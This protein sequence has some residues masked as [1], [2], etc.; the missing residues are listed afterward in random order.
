MKMVWGLHRVP[1]VRVILM[2]LAVTFEGLA[3]LRSMA[4]E[5]SPTI[6]AT[7]TQVS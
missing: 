4:L 5:Y 6:A 7:P 2:K 3:R 1:T